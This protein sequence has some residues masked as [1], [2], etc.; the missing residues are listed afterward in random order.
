MK[1]RHE[2]KHEISKLDCFELRSR[3]SAVA[4]PDKNGK[5]GCYSVRSLY[6]DDLRDTALLEKINGVSRR[7]KF[8][9]RCY[10]MDFSYICLEKKS[11]IDKLCHK[12]SYQIT[13]EEVQAIL[14]G[15]IQWMAQSESQILREFYCKIR[16]KGLRA[17]TVVDYKR[18][19]YVFPAGNVR[20]TMD[21]DIRTGIWS[22][23]FLNPDCVTIPTAGSTVILEVKWDE[24]LPDIIKDAVQLSGRRTSAFSK[25]AACRIY[26]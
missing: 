19:A 20:V 8:R 3:L 14:D 16:T 9:I 5:N 2:W 7:E 23:D 13:A 1:F 11:K 12:E 25:Y 24:F 21:S 6:F 22:T 17:K 18:E 10:N 26:D 4:Y 15:E